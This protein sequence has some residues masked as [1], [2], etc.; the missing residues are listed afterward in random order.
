M[1]EWMDLKSEIVGVCRFI[2][3]S[4]PSLWGS[5]Q[6]CIIRKKL[7]AENVWKIFAK[8]A[9]NWKIC[10]D[11]NKFISIPICP[12]FLVS[13]LLAIV[14]NLLGLIKNTKIWLIK[15]NA[16]FL[17]FKNISKTKTPQGIKQ[18]TNK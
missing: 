8:N 5:A 17:F 15:Q 2:D 4:K 18:A 11:A 10:C 12:Q 1:N 7:K 3:C 9:F 16:I 13:V 14:L 6:L